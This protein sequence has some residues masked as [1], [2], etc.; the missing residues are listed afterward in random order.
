MPRSLLHLDRALIFLLLLLLLLLLLYLNATS[1]GA[2]L[3]S[4]MAQ[5]AVAE[6][7][8]CL[9]KFSE[10]SALVYLLSKYYTKLIM[11]RTFQ[12]VCRL[13]QCADARNLSQC[14]GKFTVNNSQCTVKDV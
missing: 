3:P 13:P 10:V 12:N 2:Y 8:G 11:Q 7:C 14:P 6:K 5:D 9:H 4:G 1:T